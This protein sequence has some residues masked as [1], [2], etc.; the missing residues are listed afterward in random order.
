MLFFR[1]SP[2]KLS[3]KYKTSVVR[4]KTLTYPFKG[5]D[6]RLFDSIPFFDP[7]IPGY[8]KINITMSEMCANTHKQSKLLNFRW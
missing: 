8:S 2:I 7:N 3:T 6:L 5:G 1:K 4:R